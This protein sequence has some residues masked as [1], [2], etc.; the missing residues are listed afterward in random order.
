MWS[1]KTKRRTE[2]EILLQT[3]VGRILKS[4]LRLPTKKIEGEGVKNI[5]SN[6]FDT[7]AILEISLG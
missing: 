7:W 3:Y 1:D 2:T 4:E 6:I 5:P